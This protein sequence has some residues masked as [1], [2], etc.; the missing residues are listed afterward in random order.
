MQPAVIGQQIN[1]NAILPELPK[2]LT[3]QNQK[4]HID[5]PF[6]GGT[7]VTAT[8]ETTDPVVATNPSITF[9]WTA[10]SKTMPYVVTYNYMLTNGQIGAVEAKFNVDGPVK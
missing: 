3:L 2:G 6:I 4:W 5:G 9:Y 7:T 10:P 8:T 1:L